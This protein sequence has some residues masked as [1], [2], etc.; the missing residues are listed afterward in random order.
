M[1]KLLIII[2]KM[3]NE[4]S[5]LTGLE[6]EEKAVEVT[7]FWTHNSALLDNDNNTSLSVFIGESFVEGPLWTIHTPL[8]KMAKVSNIRCKIHLR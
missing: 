8:E 2:N 7:D 1:Y 4:S 6:I 5:K 3:G